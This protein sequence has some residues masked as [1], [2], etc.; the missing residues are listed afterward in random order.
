MAGAL[1]QLWQPKSRGL[2]TWYSGSRLAG[3]GPKGLGKMAVGGEQKGLG[4]P[5]ISHLPFLSEEQTRDSTPDWQRLK[6]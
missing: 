5:R 2:Q 3:P 1:L 4:D 6:C